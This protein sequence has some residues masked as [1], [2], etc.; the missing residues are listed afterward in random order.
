MVTPAAP[1]ETIEAQGAAELLKRIPALPTASAKLLGMMGNPN[2]SLKQISDLI[3]S[4]GVLTIET[5]RIANSAMFGSRGEIKSLL[6]AL[7]V[8]GCEKVKGIV[9]TIAL[10]NYTGNVLQ[11]P[12]LKR[13]WRHNLATAVVA[14]E[15][16]SWARADTADAYTAGLL[17]DIGR[18]ALIAFDSSKYLQVLDHAASSG[19]SLEDAERAAF[20][21]DHAVAGA[22]LAKLWGLPESLQAA[23]RDHHSSNPGSSFAITGLVQHSC[24]IADSLCFSVIESSYVTDEPIFDFLNLLPEQQRTRLNI[25]PLEFQMLIASRVN[26]MES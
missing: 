6:Q 23:I 14:D 5:L 17:H 21:V 13:C 22:W 3:A 26:A 15:I 19:D 24:R 9:C 12:A 4:D 10:R 20:K 8:L 18:L 25:D 16:A 2:I 1:P 7:A 11:I